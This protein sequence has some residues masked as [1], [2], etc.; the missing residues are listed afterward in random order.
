[1]ALLSHFRRLAGWWPR[2]ARLYR[3]EA[4]A[5]LGRL[6]MADQAERACSVLAYGDLK[7]VEL[8]MALAFFIFRIPK[9]L[10]IQRSKFG[11]LRIREAFIDPE[12]C[13]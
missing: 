4:H 3:D 13:V 10:F 8:A 2:A 11:I 6:G 1:M 5:L 12:Y 7:R 9:H